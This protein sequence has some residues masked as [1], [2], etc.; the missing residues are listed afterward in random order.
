MWSLGRVARGARARAG[1]GCSTSGRPDPGVRVFYGHDRGPGAGRA[2]RRG[3]REVPAAGDPVP[4]PADRLLAPLPRLDVAAA[5][6]SRAALARAAALASRSCST[7]TASAIRAGR[8]SDAETFNRPLRTV[9]GAA[10]HVLYQSE[11]CKRAADELVGRACRNVGGPAQ[12]RRRSGTSRRRSSLPRAGPSCSSGAT[13][14]RPTAS[15]SGSRRSRRSCRRIPT[16]SSSS[17]G[18]S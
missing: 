16:R 6:P 15:S 8:A 10:E 2:R 4:E 1:R 12:R 17:P 3:H 18:G 13:S 11:F 7:R 14:T 9:L 5:R